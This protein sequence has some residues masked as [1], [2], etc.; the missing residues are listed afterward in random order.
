[1]ADDEQ[2]L[3]E[4]RQ[5]PPTT[6]DV[7]ANEPASARTNW[8]LIAVGGV[9][10]AAVLAAL[11]ALWAGG[12]F[13]GSDDL[14]PRLAALEQQAREFANR[15]QPAPGVD[16]SALSELAARVSAAEQA[17]G[18][19]ADLDARLAKLEAAPA[20]PPPAGPD[21]ALTAR[22]T[23]LEATVR[24]LAD[25]RQSI[26]TATATARD[27][28]SRADAA[29]EAAQKASPPAVTPAQLE[30]LAARV[31]ALE[32]AAKSAEEKITRTA[33]ADRIGRLAFMAVA[34]RNAVERGEPFA[35]E[36]AAAKP[37][38]PDAAALSVLEP[39]ATTG[40]PRTAALARELSQLTGPMLGA[41]GTAPREGGFLDRRAWHVASGCARARGA[42]DQKGAGA[43]RC[44]RRGPR[45][46]RE[47][48]R[49]AEQG[50]AMTGPRA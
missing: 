33:G 43:T 21:Q 32:Q 16:R 5:R 15:P 34:L 27:A 22:V 1:M 42:V 3:P 25:V 44:A 10:A 50:G 20:A 29:F 17:L 18:R 6:I 31:A 37:L 24:P 41:A 19:L 47:R 9:A 28:K 46:R 36:L 13:P 4:K 8:W 35:Q 49:S 23:A 7:E 14:A 30:A 48:D 39:F 45:P 12:V 2:E 38:A 11:V 40:V 26:E